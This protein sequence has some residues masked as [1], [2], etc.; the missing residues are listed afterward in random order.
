MFHKTEFEKTTAIGH[1]E[2]CVEALSDS[3]VYKARKI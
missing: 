1:P 2:K 3:F